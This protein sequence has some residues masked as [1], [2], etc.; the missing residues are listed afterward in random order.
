MTYHK[1]TS[2]FFLKRGIALLNLLRTE[3]WHPFIERLFVC[4]RFSESPQTIF[5]YIFC[6]LVWIGRL[7]METFYGEGPHHELYTAFAGLYFC[8]LAL[9]GIHIFSNLVPRG[10]TNVLNRVKFYA[11]LVLFF[12]EILD[13]SNQELVIQS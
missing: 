5:Y 8:W 12:L 13:D 2:F 6:V 4:K 1:F 3:L 9:R 11:V 10:W 7:L